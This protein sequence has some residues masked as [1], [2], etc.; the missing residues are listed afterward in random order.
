M[1]L[2]IRSRSPKSN[3]FFPPSDVSVL[4]LSNS[5]HWLK[6][7]CSHKLFTALRNLQRAVTLRELAPSP[8]IFLCRYILLISM[9]L[10]KLMNIHHC[11][12]KILGKNQSVMDGHT[13]GHGNSRPTGGRG[14]IIMFEPYNQ[15]F[16]LM[17]EFNQC[18]ST[19]LYALTSCDE[20]LWSI[21]QL[22]PVQKMWS[23]FFMEVSPYV[24]L[25]IKNILA[26]WYGTFIQKL[27][28]FL[29]DNLLTCS[30]VYC[31]LSG[32]RASDA[33]LHILSVPCVAPVTTLDVQSH[34]QLTY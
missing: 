1:T 27:K 7:Q 23:F 8:C 11:V 22:I 32:P 10:Q 30:A 18:P 21:P 20:I 9:C 4:V 33:G 2:K 17:A 16:T 12:F 13:D 15:N 3:H 24:F 14:G 31:L 25:N 26:V 29:T 28:I 6:R 19:L 34:Q 5:G